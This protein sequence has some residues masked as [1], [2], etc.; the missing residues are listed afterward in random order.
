M[1]HY[2]NGNHIGEDADLISSDVAHSGFLCVLNKTYKVLHADGEF[3]MET[4]EVAV[5][6]SST[7]AALVVHSKTRTVW[8][9][10]QFR[11][12]IGG[13]IIALPSGYVDE[14]ETPL[15]AVI[16]EVKEEVGVAVNSFERICGF[17]SS[18]GWTDE[19]NTL[20]L[21][22]IS[23]MP[24]AESMQGI[25]AEGERIEL[26]PMTTDAFCES[27]QRGTAKTIIAAQW[28]ALNRERL[29]V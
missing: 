23:E 16:R 8:L 22:S 12:A 15:Q 4:R 6:K 5:V 21:C 26:F 28:L 1:L 11:A 25:A 24:D 3:S 17:Y 2:P 29:G 7:V 14:S 9:V 18:P 13:W 10:R 19:Y 27:A 20:Y